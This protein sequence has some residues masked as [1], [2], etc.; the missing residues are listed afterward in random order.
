MK[1]IEVIAK[2]SNYKLQYYSKEMALCQKMSISK[3]INLSI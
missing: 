2:Y 1:D 3:I